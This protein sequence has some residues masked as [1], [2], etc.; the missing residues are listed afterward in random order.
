MVY[1]LYEIV[2]L[3]D[4][5][6]SSSKQILQKIPNIF[7]HMYELDR[8]INLNINSYCKSHIIGKQLRKKLT[9]YLETAI[10]TKITSTQ[11]GE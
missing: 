5:L 9:E 6:L 11:K 3:V 4:L 8:T 2:E 7:N 10:R 1:P